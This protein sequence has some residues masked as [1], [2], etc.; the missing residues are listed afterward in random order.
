MPSQELPLFTNTSWYCPYIWNKTNTIMQEG[1]LLDRMFNE[2]YLGGTKSNETNWPVAGTN[3]GPPAQIQDGPAVVD[4]REGPVENDG[5]IQDPVEQ[6]RPAVALRQEGL[7]GLAAGT[8]RVGDGK[9]DHSSSSSESDS[10]CGSL[11]E[12]KIERIL[13]QKKGSKKK[14]KRDQ[15]KRDA[16]KMAESLKL[17]RALLDEQFKR[18]AEFQENIMK[19]VQAT[20]SLLPSTSNRPAMTGVGGAEFGYQPIVTPV[21]ARHNAWVMADQTSG[22][23]SSSHHGPSLGTEGWVKQEGEGKYGIAGRGAWNGPS[24]TVHKDK[25]ARRRHLN[26]LKGQARDEEAARLQQREQSREAMTMA[27]KERVK[28]MEVTT[29]RV[30]NRENKGLGLPRP[31]RVRVERYRVT[32]HSVETESG[33]V[34]GLFKLGKNPPE[35][36]SRSVIW[37]PSKMEQYAPAWREY[38]EKKGWPAE[39]G[40]PNATTSDSSQGGQNGGRAEDRTCGDEIDEEEEVVAWCIGHRINSKG[41]VHMVLKWSDD[42]DNSLAR[43]SKVMGVENERKAYGKTWLNYCDGKGFRDELFRTVGNAQV[44]NVLGHEWDDNGRPMAEVEWKHGGKLPKL[45]LQLH[46]RKI[47]T[48]IR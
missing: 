14:Q 37:D 3:N 25:N 31:T 41:H 18:M 40:N 24:T 6:L 27:V 26:M 15:K 28:K 4:S 34:M 7:L 36:I 42:P 16:E 10:S 9:R 19:M 38:C 22:S 20:G 17:E 12:G 29:T 48:T 21:V 45:L 43:V 46:W 1:L 2:Q 5:G 47:A 39:W 44:V 13:S 35:W 33:E 32:K 23:G 30:I 8:S 11:T